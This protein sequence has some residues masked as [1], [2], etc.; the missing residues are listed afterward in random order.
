MNNSNEPTT[1]ELN[2]AAKISV[3][4]GV[5]FTTA[6]ELVLD[7][8]EAADSAASAKNRG[9]AQRTSFV[10]ASEIQE[11]LTQVYG[12][13]RSDEAQDTKIAMLEEKN[14]QME[15][16]VSGIGKGL[17]DH[18]DQHVR[19]LDGEESAM[20]PSITIQLIRQALMNVK[21]YGD[22][23]KALQRFDV[24]APINLKEIPD[25]QE[26][27]QEIEVQKKSKWGLF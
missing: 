8:P 19:V 10:S 3:S 11:L 14:M 9:M 16:I 21:G 4:R 2:L 7:N 24:Q 20:Q 26:P 25:M 12:R 18:L 5:D 13:G 22:L 17:F 1:Q 6:L 15:T 23:T 27:A